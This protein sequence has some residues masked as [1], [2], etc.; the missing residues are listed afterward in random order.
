MGQLVHDTQLRMPGN[1]GID[2]QVF[3]DHAAMLDPPPRDYLEVAN[4]CRRFRSPVRVDEPDN[5]VHALAAKGMRILEHRVRLSHA[6]SRPDV[7]A[8]PRAAV[9]LDTGQ[10]LFG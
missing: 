5:D 10:P 6:R 8:E 2:V 3:Q 1:H 9:L 4:L 7:H